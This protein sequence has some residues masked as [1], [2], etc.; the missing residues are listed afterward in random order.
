MFDDQVDAFKDR[1]R[2]IAIDFRGHGQSEVTRD[3]YDMDTLTEDVAAIIR[4]LDCAPCHYVGF[5]MGGFG[6]LRL[7]IRQ[8]E[9]LKSLTLIDSACDPEPKENIPKFKLLSLIAR[10]FGLG[11]VANSVMPISFSQDF[12]TD[13]ARAVLREEWRQRLVDNDKIG[14]IRGVGGII[15][16][17]AVCDSLGEIRLPTLILVGENDTAVVPARSERMHD[18]IPNSRLVI[19]PNSGHVS[20]IEAPEAV[21]AAMDDFFSSLG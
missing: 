14:A 3:G 12:L 16:R 5:S 9:L 18:L 6:G 8:P 1:Y 15:S 10:L 11:V 13:P 17:E 19:I 20:T 4:Q 7:A 2:C 21:S